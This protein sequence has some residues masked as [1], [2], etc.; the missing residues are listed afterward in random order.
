MHSTCV[1]ISNANFYTF[2]HKYSYK[3]SIEKGYHGLNLSHA[4]LWHNKKNESAASLRQLRDEDPTVNVDFSACN[5]S[6]YGN[7]IV[8]IAWYSRFENY[9]AT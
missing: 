7:R 3:S 1:Y 2:L 4:D 9:N 6:P 8:L 5:R